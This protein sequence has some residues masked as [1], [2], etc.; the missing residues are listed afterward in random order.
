M[1]TNAEKEIQSE[2]EAEIERLKAAMQTLENEVDGLSKEKKTLEDDL[3]ALVNKTEDNSV[4]KEVRSEQK[5]EIEQLKAAMETMENEVAS[6][7]EEKKILEDN[8]LALQNKSED[9]NSV[10]KIDD[11]TKSLEQSETKAAN[12]ELGNQS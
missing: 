5:A 3:S 8:L 12:M 6:L 7:S 4:E 9:A 11:L 10:K 2:Q 1:G